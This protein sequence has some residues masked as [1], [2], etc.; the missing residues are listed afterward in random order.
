MNK[1][2]LR[3]EDKVKTSKGML[4][5]PS[6]SVCIAA[7]VQMLTA[8]MTLFGTKTREMMGK[9]VA[10][11]THARKYA[12][13]IHMVTPTA[14]DEEGR[15]KGAEQA[16]ETSPAAAEAIHRETNRR[17]VTAAAHQGFMTPC[18]RTS[19]QGQEE[20]EEEGE[21]ERETNG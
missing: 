2:Q 9:R 8:E 19:D 1:E 11:K 14:G 12:G 17:E 15:M 4:Q 20:G 5:M 6:I 13:S 18:P 3:E 21:E 16:T 10:E 7:A